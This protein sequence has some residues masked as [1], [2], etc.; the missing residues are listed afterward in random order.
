MRDEMRP[1]NMEEVEMFAAQMRELY[2]S[3]PRNLAEVYLE[4]ALE[5][6]RGRPRAAD[7][8]DLAYG[9]FGNSSG[10]LAVQ[11]QLHE[12]L[13]NE[14]AILRGWRPRKE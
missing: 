9:L 13:V 12:D 2:A 11:D 6:F 3:A 1:W 14:A 8:M 5:A 10:L 4:Q 7:V